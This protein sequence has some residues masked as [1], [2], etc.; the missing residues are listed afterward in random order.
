MLHLA[1]LCWAIA[2][3]SFWSY[4]STNAFKNEEVHLIIVNSQLAMHQWPSTQNSNLTKFC[5]TNFV[6]LKLL[7]LPDCNN[8]H[9]L[10]ILPPGKR[11]GKAV[12][13]KMWKQ[14]TELM[15]LLLSWYWGISDS[16]MLRLHIVNLMLVS[17]DGMLMIWHLASTRSWF[18]TERYK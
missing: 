5:C 7:L 10:K 1:V 17:Q 6:V 18:H 14:T 2:S 3:L 8:V 11:E 16:F 12:C 9:S 13:T 4:R 15:C